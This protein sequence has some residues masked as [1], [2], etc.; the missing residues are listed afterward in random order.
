MRKELTTHVFFVYMLG[1]ICGPAFAVSLPNV[2]AK[3]AESSEIFEMH[4]VLFEVATYCS[5][6]L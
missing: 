5:N 4:E 1:G 2:Q 6:A 3:L